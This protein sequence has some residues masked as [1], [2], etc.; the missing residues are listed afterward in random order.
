MAP[1]AKKNGNG[2]GKTAKTAKPAKT[3]K[4]RR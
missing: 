1:A 3:A 4:T 2:N